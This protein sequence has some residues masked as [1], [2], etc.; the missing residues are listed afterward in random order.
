[1]LVCVFATAGVSASTAAQPPPPPCG[2]VAGRARAEQA[3]RA[4]DQVSSMDGARTAAKKSAASAATGRHPRALLASAS[5]LGL[6]RSAGTGESVT[7]VFFEAQYPATTR[8]SQKL[9]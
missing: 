1:M 3:G 8:T 2:A 4:S 6:C 9:L 5:A 7:V